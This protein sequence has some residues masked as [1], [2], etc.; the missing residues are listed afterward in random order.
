MRMHD[1]R[2]LDISKVVTFTLPQGH[3]GQQC[4]NYEKYTVISQTLLDLKLLPVKKTA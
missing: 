1:L 3:A 2:D 4:V